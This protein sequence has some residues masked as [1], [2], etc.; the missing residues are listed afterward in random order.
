MFVF[1]ETKKFSIGGNLV[2]LVGSGIWV[3]VQPPQSTQALSGVLLTSNGAFKFP[4]ALADGSTYTIQLGAQ[5][6]TPFQT[7]S[8][9]NGTG[10][11]NGGDITNIS[12]TCTTTT[13]AL[14][15]TVTGLHGQGL[16]LRNNGG[17]DIAIDHDGAFTFPNRIDSVTPIEVTVAVSPTNLTQTRHIINGLLS[18]GRG[19]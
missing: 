5:P 3:L 7:C 17:N 10:T 14:G 9:A 1:C 2:G 8:V 19:V 4:E 6:V 15:G 11:V 16:V 18:L 12:V 13:Y